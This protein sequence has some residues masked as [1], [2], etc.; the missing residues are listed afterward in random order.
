MVI[1]S[2]MRRTVTPVISAA[3]TLALMVSF[4]VTALAGLVFLHQKRVARRIRAA[5]SDNG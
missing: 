4:A 5:E 1:W 3:S 2:M